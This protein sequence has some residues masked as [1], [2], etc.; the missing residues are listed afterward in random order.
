MGLL[1]V[2]LQKIPA[3]ALETWSGKG[4]SSSKT[5]YVRRGGAV[6][7]NRRAGFRF[8]K[9]AEAEVLNLESGYEN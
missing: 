8:E 9:Y 2:P 6:S 4:R 3:R 1:S 5:V 7:G